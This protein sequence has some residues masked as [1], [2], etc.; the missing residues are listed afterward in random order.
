ML[1]DT[2][3]VAAPPGRRQPRRARQAVL[4]GALER[5]YMMS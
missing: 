4:G 1:N 5:T 3:R 2:E